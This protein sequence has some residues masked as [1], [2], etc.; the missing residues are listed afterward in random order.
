MHIDTDHDTSQPRIENPKFDEDLPLDLARWTTKY[1]S[2]DQKNTDGAQPIMIE[3]RLGDSSTPAQTFE[4]NVA[5]L[6]S[7]LSLVSANTKFHTPKCFRPKGSGGLDPIQ[8]PLET[9]ICES[10]IPE[11]GIRFY[12]AREL[13]TAVY[14]LLCTGWLHK[15]IRS[16]NVVL[17]ERRKAGDPVLRT[18][19][20][21]YLLGFE[22]ARPDQLGQKSLNDKENEDLD[23]YRHPA[24]AS[25]R[26]GSD[27]YRI[28]SYQKQYDIYSLGVVLLEI[29][30]WRTAVYLKNGY[31]E[32]QRRGKISEETSS[33]CLQHKAMADL[34][35]QMGQKYTDLVL[36]CLRGTFSVEQPDSQGASLR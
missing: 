36:H 5:E 7:L 24:T 13:A 18:E 30:L 20:T 25:T 27:G 21:V 26:W 10:I 32:R 15:G 19:A 3:W 31:R 8:R 17:F 4:K 14:Y 35:F 33:T 34:P 28:H 12:I 29:G 16:H 23:L 9:A 22:F 11:L 1:T 6:S 2:S